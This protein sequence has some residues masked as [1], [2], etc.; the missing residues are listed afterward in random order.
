MSASISIAA[1]DTAKQAG[2]LAGPAL[3]AAAIAIAAG[4]FLVVLDSTITNVSVPTIAGALGVS[5]N[6]G[7]WVITSYAVAEAITVPLTGWLAKKFGSQRVFITCYL[8]FAALSVFCGLS[9]SLGM[10]I[11][12]RVLLG[13]LGGPI[14]PLAQTMLVRVFPP[15]MASLATV[16]YAIT[17]LVGPIAGP[18]LGGLICDNAGWQWIFFITAPF[19][20]G[21]GMAV[22]LLMRGQPDPR[23]K[24][25]IDVVG[26]GLLIV[27]IG[28]LQIML[29][30]GRDQDW[31]AS[32]QICMLAAIA[33]F[34]FLSFL[35]W[36][37][38][39]K[40][41]I[42]DLRIFR[43]RG[44]AAVCATYMFGFGAF[45]AVIV[46]IPLW[47]QQNMG[48]T[49]T[50]AGYATGIMGILAVL[51]GP[52]IAKA[53]EKFDPRLII[54]IGLI[55]MGGLNAYRTSFNSNVTFL[56]LAIPTLLYGPFLV[57]FFVPLNG[58][59]LSTVDPDEQANAAGLSNFLRT[60][61]GAF[62][63]SLVQTSWSDAGRRAQ[64]ELAGA[65]VH[66][67]ATLHDLRST[68][69]A[70][71]VAL[72]TLSRMV[73]NQSV[74]LATLQTFG[75]VAIVFFLS[76]AIVWIVPKPIG[77]IAMDGGH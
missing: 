5:A 73:E 37:L 31:F 50:N 77:P 24:A 10:L 52:L 34:A 35:I 12:G 51:S 55:G 30:E 39:E 7:T 75:I 29:D 43:H 45:F 20:L 21:G 14:M 1:G 26:L 19:A 25:A 56:Q 40:H 67:S 64:S 65:M 70:P 18:I 4:N 16:V 74:M 27:W 46:I 60:I 63:T 62:A 72:G 28:A 8:G 33:I 41:P 59:A 57:M 23:E 38:T 69:M 15:R 49:A 3:F 9:R 66:A 47:L 68:G 76:A 48:Y 42:V 6:Q 32:P 11:A 44:F 36:V 58:L 54:A 2:P 61:G 22:L 71:Q 17:T 13:L 53:V